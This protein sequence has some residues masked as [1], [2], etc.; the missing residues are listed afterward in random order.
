MR[1]FPDINPMTFD[2][3][4]PPVPRGSSWPAGHNLDLHASEDTAMLR[5]AFGLERPALS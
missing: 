5:R 3:R 2:R 4:C 1:R